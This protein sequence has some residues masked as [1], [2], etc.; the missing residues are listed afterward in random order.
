MKLTFYY[1]RHGETLFNR[2]RR[3]Q[4]MCDSPLTE[5]GIA[6]A[7]DTASALQKIPF[8]RCFCSASERAY[9][10][11]DILCR[12][13]DGLVP[14][15]L[16]ELKEFDFG[17]LDG[18]HIDEF[19][20]QIQP[21]RMKDDWSHVGGENVE[22][23]RI[24]AGKAFEKIISSCRDGD[25]VLL[26]SHGSYFMHLIKTLIEYDQQDYI[27]RMNEQ[28]RPF[29][30]NAS[31]SVFTWEDGVFDLVR[32]PVTADEFR[33]LEHRHVD[34][35][36][37]RHG[38]TKFNTEKRLQGLCDSPL[39]EKGI[40]QAEA[41]AEALK[42]VPFAKAYCSSLERTRDTAQIILRY[43]DIEAKPDKRLREVFFGSYEAMEFANIRDELMERHIHTRWKDLGGEDKEDVS[44]RILS[45]F[46]EA[47]DSADDGDTILLV[48][49]GDMYLCILETLFHKNKA[50]VYAEAEKAGVNPMPN[51]GI[52]RFAYDDGRFA[53]T[54][55]M[56][57]PGE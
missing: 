45:F 5:K 27:R 38:E 8:D 49:H 26:V 19:M 56:K 33:A 13:H 30:P 41:A 43:H 3:M 37:V 12:F 22:R 2:I 35:Y 29:V 17:E 51:A 36:F 46:R 34:F 15:P 50:D 20:D 14:V 54:E 24:R 52:F 48:S 23:F 9:D 18:K 10:T 47:A 25:T 21:N 32:E 39:T 57:G 31:V 11:A 42:D 53:V 55:M 44:G 4:G 1:V 6:Q 7:E 40:A 28:K 16:K